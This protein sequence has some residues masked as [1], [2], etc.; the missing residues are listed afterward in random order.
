MK[1]KMFTL[2]LI[3]GM[4]LS[5]WVAERSLIPRIVNHVH[6]EAYEHGLMIKEIDHETDEVIYRWI[7]THNFGYEE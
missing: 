5:A 6:R 7:E 4:L 3:T 2:G 1:T